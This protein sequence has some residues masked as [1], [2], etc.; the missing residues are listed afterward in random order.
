MYYDFYGIKHSPF[1][2]TSNPDFFFESAS[3][4]E[5][6]ATLLYGIKEKKGIILITGE[7]GTGKTTLCKTLLGRLPRNVKTSLILNPYF[8]QVQLLQAIADDFGISL[9]AKDKLGIVKELN[10]FLLS[11]GKDNSTAAV[12]IDEAQDL[13]PRQLEQ[14][15]LLSNLETSYSKLLQII[16]VG[17]PELKYKLNHPKLRQMRQRIFVKYELSSLKNEEVKNYIYFRLDKAGI[18]DVDIPADSLNLIYDFSRG[19]PRLINMLCDRALL[20]GFVRGKKVLDEEIFKAC[21][22]ELK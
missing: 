3:H 19:I 1:N 8:S 5:A 18:K 13:T 9:P 15:R 11:L 14:V 20:G 21:I 2:I 10:F 6:L 22:D 16:L 12:I 17:Q 7:V 4:R